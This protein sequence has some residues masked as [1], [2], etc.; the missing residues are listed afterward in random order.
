MEEELL[1]KLILSLG[2]P[3]SFSADG[4]SSTSHSLKEQI[5]LYRFLQAEQAKAAGLRK[6][7]LRFTQIVPK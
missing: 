7:K 5:E 2:D 6:N 3:K 4:V 1:N